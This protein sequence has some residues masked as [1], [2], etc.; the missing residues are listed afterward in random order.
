MA[1][2]NLS[3]RAYDRILKV[4]RM[5]A[6]LADSEALGSDTSPKPFNIAPST[7]RLGIA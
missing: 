4:V 7:G 3:V 2:W 6:D 1:D 5:I